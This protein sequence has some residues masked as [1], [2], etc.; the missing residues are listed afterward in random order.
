MKKEKKQEESFRCL[1]CGRI[2]KNPSSQRIGLGKVCAAKQLEDYYR[3]N[4]LT[5]DLN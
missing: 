5:I 2:L 3:K 4:Q 1:R